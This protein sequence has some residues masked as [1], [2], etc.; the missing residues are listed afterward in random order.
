[1]GWKARF[2]PVEVGRRGFVGIVQLLRSTGMT[3]SSL[4]K[5][6]EELGE[7]ARKASYWLWLWRRKTLSKHPFKG[8]CRK[9][10]GGIPN[11]PSTP[12]SAAGTYTSIEGKAL[13]NG[14]LQLILQLT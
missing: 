1:M 11:T 6:V 5:A 10:Q 7:E 8:S 9:W 14:G 13:V 12:T 4:Q 2:Y 3:G